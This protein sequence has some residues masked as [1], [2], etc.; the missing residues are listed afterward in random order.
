MRKTKY[1]TK[2]NQK[3]KKEDF[4]NLIFKN[5]VIHDELKVICNKKLKR[6]RNSAI[7]ELEVLKLKITKLRRFFWRY[8][9]G[10]MEPPFVINLVQ[11]KDVETTLHISIVFS[12]RVFNS[13]KTI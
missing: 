13:T 1:S 12:R 5:D 9:A 7:L 11:I 10:N 3:F 4:Q 8:W 6:P 2:F